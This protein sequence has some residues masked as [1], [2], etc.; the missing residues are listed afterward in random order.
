MKRGFFITNGLA[1][2]FALV[3]IGWLVYDFIAYDFLYSKMSRLESLTAVDVTIANFIWLGLAVFLVFHIIGFIAVASQF[4]YFRKASALR[5]LALAAGILACIMILVDVAGLSDVYNEYEK[6]RVAGEWRLLDTV[7]AI[8]GIFFLA[9][10]ANL[11]EAFIQSRKIRKDEKVIK[12]EVILILLHCVGVFCGIVGLFFSNAAFV[13]RPAHTQLQITF[14]FLFVFALIPYGLLA[15]YWLAVKLKEKPADWYDEK[16][17]QDI[18]KAGLLTMLVTIP[19]LGMV[20][21]FN[22][23]VPKGPIHILW[24]PFYLYFVMLVFSLTSLYFSWR[25]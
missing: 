17:F 18:S 10:I 4:R 2:F 13:F 12:D 11:F 23:G 9:I 8:R 25:D 15:G 20:Y 7:A 21:I 14:P 3:S 5:I 24:F 6:G 16:Q 22:Y 19:Y 1:F